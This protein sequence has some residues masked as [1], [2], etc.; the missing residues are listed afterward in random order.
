MIIQATAA[1]LEVEKTERVTGPRVLHRLEHGR[2]G[3]VP[4]RRKFVGVRGDRADFGGGG[5]HRIA[6]NTAEGRADVDH[7]RIGRRRFTD[8]N[9]KMNEAFKNNGNDVKLTNW[10]G[11]ATAWGTFLSDDAVL[12]LAAGTQAQ[13]KAPPAGGGSADAARGACSAAAGKCDAGEPAGAAAGRVEQCQSAADGSGSDE[14]RADERGRQ[15][16]V[17]GPKPATTD[18]PVTV[19]GDNADYAQAAG[20]GSNSGRAGEHVHG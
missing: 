12:Q 19:S 6:P 9:L 10:Q 15:R 2:T 14:C 1:L 5:A 7:L 4:W 3:R 16:M 18:K 17:S 11:E 20:S 8:G 13:A